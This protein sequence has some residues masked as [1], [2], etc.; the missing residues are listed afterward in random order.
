MEIPT[1]YCRKMAAGAR[2]GGDD[3]IRE[4]AVRVCEMRNPRRPDKRRIEA[5]F[6]LWLG[7]LE[8]ASTVRSTS[9]KRCRSTV[10]GSTLTLHC[11]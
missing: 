5:W 8:A 9:G 6:R 10:R 3:E 1:T 7:R 4:V 2:R 11:C